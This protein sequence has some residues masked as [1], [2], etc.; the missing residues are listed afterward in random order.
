MFI[1]FNTLFYNILYIIYFIFL[2]LYLNI[3]IIIIR[4]MLTDILRVMVNNPFKESFY[5]KRKKIINVSTIFSISYKN[6]VKTFLKQIVNHCSKDTRQHDPYYYYYYFGFS[7]P[8]NHKRLEDRE[9][10]SNARPITNLTQ[11]REKV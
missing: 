1:Y 4:E 7:R 10:M 11:Q 6:S 3:I 5:G 2:P 9:I 8:N